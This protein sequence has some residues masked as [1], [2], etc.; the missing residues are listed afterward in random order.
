MKNYLIYEIIY[1]FI[2][3]ITIINIKQLERKKDKS[4][5]NLC[6]NLIVILI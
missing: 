6:L 2:L 3:I 5:E 1:Y 4:E